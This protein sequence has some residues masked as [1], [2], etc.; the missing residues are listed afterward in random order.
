MQNKLVL[1]GLEPLI[2]TDASNFINIGERTNVTGSK[3]FL[4]LIKLGKYEEALDVAR[5]Q[6]EGGAQVLDINMDEAMIDGKAAM[7]RFLRLVAAEPD[8]C[9]IPIMIDSSKWDIIEEGLKNVQGKSIVNSISLKDGEETFKYRALKIKR[10]GGA[11]VVMAFDE[12]GQADNYQKRIDICKRSYD[13]M[14]NEYGF[15]PSDIIFDPNI[16]PIGTG[17]E[18]HRKNATD[19]FDAT[20]W[21]KQNLKGALISGGVSNVSFSFRGNDTVREA[22]NTAFL[23]H[24]IQSG[25]D[26]GI[27]NPTL[28][29]VYSEIPKDLLEKIEDVLFDRSDEATDNLINFAEGVVAGTDKKENEV[30]EWRSYTI[31]AKI[32]YAL[33]RGITQYIDEDMQEAL[34][35]YKIPLKIIEGPLMDGMNVV[36]DLFG[37]GKMFLPQVV[38]SA[39]VMKKAV[40]YLTPIIEEENLR[41][42]TVSTKTKILMATVKGD[43]HDIGKNI[44]SVVL[45]CNGYEIIDLGVMVPAEKILDT[46]IK[47][48][49]AIIGL[50]GL[51]TPS[52]DEM[53]YVAQQMKERKMDIP[54]LIGGATTSV[55]HTAVKI[56]PEYDRGVIHVNDASKSVGVVSNLIGEKKE[57][58]LQEISESYTK[59]RDGYLGR[60]KENVVLTIEKARENKLKLEFNPVKP[61]ELGIKVLHPTLDEII[62]FIDWTPFFKTWELRGVYPKIFEDVYVG[63]LAKQMFEEAQLMLDIIKKE[64]H[65]DLKIIYGLFK[66][67]T[68]NDDQIKLY[69]EDGT[70]L[71][72]FQ[73][74]RQQTIHKKK[75][76]NLSLSDFIAPVESGIEDYIGCFAVTSGSKLETFAKF[77]QDNLDDYNSILVK[78]IADRL[79]EALAE[80]I[81]LK[82][83]K[84]IWG[85]EPKEDLTVTELIKEKY[86]GIRPAPGYPASPD[87]LEKNTIW[88]ILKPDEEIGV[89]LTESLAMYPAAAVCG[90]FFAHPE[91]KYFGLGRIGKDQVE[92]FA[93]RKNIEF[94]L[95]EKWLSPSLAY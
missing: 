34:D 68:F 73:T 7:I 3:K 92:D 87:H 62:P 57:S 10:F 56:I 81:H 41:T 17:M 94:K 27:V 78:A 29:G 60:K 8:I 36:G 14:V 39:R 45:G 75:E 63:E 71:T 22:I 83:R 66:A 80:Y 43:V 49:V 18:E 35:K 38:K 77:Y 15:N 30:E 59:I 85:Y 40:A 46:A 61:N 31:E 84:E 86:V 74:L 50:S 9:R 12:N 6:V 25:M 58:L 42:N 65:D 82:V 47:E 72:V 33:V 4:K 76:P 53:V 90:I 54:L 67:N 23:Y 5:D 21:I 89:I 79:A 11:V 70:E 91:A 16:F 2:A 13:L 51:I 1:S 95:A 48:N 37:S 26:M 88:D 32:S 19:F 64:K 52:L 24:A 93:K 69:N 28:L 44:V 55:A 20:K